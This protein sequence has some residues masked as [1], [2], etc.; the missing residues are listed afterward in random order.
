MSIRLCRGASARTAAA[1][2]VALALVGAAGRAQAERELQGTVNASGGYTT[3][4]GATAEA[5]DPV[6]S[7]FLQVQPALT[8]TWGSA[9]TVERASVSATFS[10]FTADGAESLG[11][12]SAQ[13]AFAVAH[14]VDQ[15]TDV[16]VEIAASVQQ[17]N[18][19]SLDAPAGGGQAGALPGGTPATFVGA[20]IQQ[21][22]SHHFSPVWR[23]VEGFALGLA[24]PIDAD[25]YSATAGLELGAER[26]WESQS[27]TIEGG[28]GYS[29]ITQGTDQSV[30]LAR[31]GLRY[32]RQLSRSWHAELAGGGLFAIETEDGKNAVLPVGSAALEYRVDEGTAG[33]VA[34]RSATLNPYL[35]QNLVVDDLG[36]RAGLPLVAKTLTLGGAA[37]VQRAQ[38]LVPSTGT[39]DYTLAVVYVDVGLSYKVRENLEFG[40]RYQFTDQ[41]SDDAGAPPDFTRHL[42]LVTVTGRY[43]DETRTRLPFR[44]PM[45]MERTDLDQLDER[46]TLRR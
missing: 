38:S 42:G 23:G 40:A 28:T 16:L 9:R 29:L 21:G 18:T 17:T 31:A 24:V 11:S 5:D 25:G 1:A 20:G 34:S 13:A 12:T 44:R 32:R 45:R 36:V 19:A 35:G 6:E 14:A 15:R 33:V 3:N 2:S 27:F 39:V 26:S 22:L 4:A 43:P 46:R 7:P 37:G 8:L 30:V 41:R 10:R